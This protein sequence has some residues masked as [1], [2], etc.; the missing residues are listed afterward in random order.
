[1]FQHFSFVLLFWSVFLDFFIC[2]SSWT[3]HLGFDFFFFVL[4]EGI[5]IFSQTN[6]APVWISSFNSVTLFFYIYVSTWFIFSMSILTVLHSM[7]LS[8][9]KVVFFL[10]II[11]FK[12]SKFIFC[13]CASVCSTM[14]FGCAVFLF[15]EV[16]GSFRLDWS[17]LS[18]VGM[19]VIVLVS[20]SL[21]V[22][23]CIS[24]IS[25]SENHPLLLYQ[26][27]QQV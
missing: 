2:I 4:F 17:C 6:F 22:F 27:G 18:I 20:C 7:F 25:R 24:S 11:I 26:L 5:L 13:S 21:F 23:R 9:G 10:F 8:D 16:D 15:S 3:S 14:S 1:M 12:F 19:S